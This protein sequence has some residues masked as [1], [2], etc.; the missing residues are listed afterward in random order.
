MLSAV[1]CQQQRYHFPKVTE[2]VKPALIILVTLWISE[3]LF[4]GLH[5]VLP[6]MKSAIGQALL[7]RIE[8]PYGHK[9][10]AEKIN[11]NVIQTSLYG[12]SLCEERIFH[13]RYFCFWYTP[14]SSCQFWDVLD[15]SK[16]PLS[17]NQHPKWSSQSCRFVIRTSPLH[18]F[19]CFNLFL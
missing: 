15:W 14:G 12:D 17:Y 2:L 3:R 1:K 19:R 10:L 7:N 8:L 18:S 11:I 13:W 6:Y 5:R 16:F 4:S 9:D